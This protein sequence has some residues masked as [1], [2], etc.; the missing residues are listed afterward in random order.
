MKFTTSI[1]KISDG[2]ESIRGIALSELVEKH[3][4]IETIFLLLRSKLPNEKEVRMMNALLTAA[5]DHGPGTASALAARVSA[6]AKNDVHASVAAGILGMGQR[7]GMA[8]EG[9]A[10][11]L[12]ENVSTNDVSSLVKELKA[13]KMRVSGYG[14][15]ILS[16]DER[17]DMLF[18]VA[19]QCNVY[20]KYSAFAEAFGQELN[21][22]SSKSVPLNID[23]AMAAIFL[24]MGFSV[25][26][27]GG[28]FIIARIPGLVAQVIEE[29]GSDEGLRRLDENEIVYE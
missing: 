11:F 23:G 8:I 6:S 13:K 7:H 18:A 3:S 29:R 14:H 10:K 28:L 20:S 4:F 26:M 19:R 12:E 25:S 22:Q 17:S 5:I 9:V 21:A 2:K 24:D 15:A 27:M 16:H 1:T